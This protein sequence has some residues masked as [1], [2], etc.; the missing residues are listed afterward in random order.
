MQPPKT[1]FSTKWTLF[2]LPK[3]LFSVQH[4]CNLLPLIFECCAGSRI[5]FLFL[6]HD[7]YTELL[8][9][10]KISVGVYKKIWPTQRLFQ[11]RKEIVEYRHTKSRIHDYNTVL[12]L[13]ASYVVLTLLTLLTCVQPTTNFRTVAIS[14]TLFATLHTRVDS[15]TRSSQTN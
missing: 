14:K 13:V 7:D 3:A 9:K 15:S 6:F 12:A 10:L 1:L 5:F 8:R 2:E 4:T 11:M